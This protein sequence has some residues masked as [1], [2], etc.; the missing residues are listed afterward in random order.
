PGTYTIFASFVGAEKQEQTVTLAAGQVL[1]L[2]FTLAESSTA[3]EEVIV[4]DISSNRFYSD[5]SF[6]VAKLPLKDLDN[7]QV[8]NSI[9]SRLLK[10]QVVV[11][12][13]DALENAFGVAR[14][15]ESTG[16]G[17]DGAEFYAMRGF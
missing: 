17:G 7:P 14:L 5:S 13:N 1:T 16:R 11:N 2:N 10:A 3:L 4:S 15:W 6:T 9:S 12:M 8:Y